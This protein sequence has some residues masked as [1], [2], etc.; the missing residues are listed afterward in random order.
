MSGVTRV[1]RIC[2][3]AMLLAGGCYQASPIVA[4]ALTCETEC[5][6]GYVCGGTG[7]CQLADTP[8]CPLG[9]FGLPRLVAELSLAGPSV[10]EPTFT[11]D[12]LEVVF[13]QGDAPA[14][15]LFVATRT[16]IDEPWGMPVSIMDLNMPAA[17]QANPGISPDGLTVWFARETPIGSPPFKNIYVSTRTD[18]TPSWSPPTQ[19]SELNSASYDSSPAVAADGAVMIISSNRGPNRFD[20]YAA[21]AATPT[22]WM[23]PLPIGELNTIF[24]DNAGRLWGKSLHIVF[25]SDRSRSNFD[26]IWTAARPTAADPF[27][28]LVELELGP[29][30]RDAAPWI[31][32]DGHYLMFE[33][34]R[35]G[36][37]QIY[38]ASR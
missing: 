8:D 21:Q 30:V 19:V 16:A 23:P 22:T 26:S 37:L 35:S 2:S 4:C 34:D 10:Q 18:R 31:S 33:S 7:L 12:R 25:S 17:H 13:R 3:F 29:T 28:D 36:M 24:D 32:E 20:L 6:D 38:E 14:G 5:P 11:A 27:S 9:E 15:K 1:G